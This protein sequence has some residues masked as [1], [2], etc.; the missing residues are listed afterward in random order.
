MSEVAAP[1]QAGSNAS[2]PPRRPKTFPSSG[3]ATVRALSTT[4]RRTSSL[5][6]L[7]DANEFRALSQNTI[8]LRPREAFPLTSLHDQLLLVLSGAAI[9]T[10]YSHTFDSISTVRLIGKDDQFYVGKSGTDI[11]YSIESIGTTNIACISR[12]D[13]VLLLDRFPDTAMSILSNIGQQFSGLE[14][15]VR[16]YFSISNPF[17]HVL[18]ALGALPQY[19]GADCCGSILELKVPFSLEIFALSIGISTSLVKAVVSDLTERNIVYGSWPTISI[20]ITPFNDLW[21]RYFSAIPFGD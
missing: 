18:D 12:N 7:I 21:R 11:S 16:G 3:G 13:L 8:T 9:V 14:R 4:H 5:F 10:V 6:A 15:F 19:C 2:S 17:E 20:A 1:T